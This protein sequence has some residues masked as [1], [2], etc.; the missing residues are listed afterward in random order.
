MEATTTGLYAHLKE[1]GLQGRVVPIQHL[2]DLQNQ[3]QGR[4]E[5]GEFE[6]EFY[7]ERLA[8]FSFE[9]PPKMPAPAA[10]IV[11][12]VP[13]PQ[14]RVSFT[15]QG[16]SLALVLPPTYLRYREVARETKAWVADW[17]APLGYH[18]VTA[19]LPQKLL[20]VC[21]GLAEYGR[22]NITYVPG[23]GSFQQPMA[24][25]SDL[26]PPEPDTWRAPQMMARCDKC[27][28]C[29][30]KCPTGA[31][32][33]DR[34]LLHAER[35][36]VYHNERSGEHPFPPWI[37]PAAHNSVMG[38]MTCQQY[39]PEDK[40]FLGWFEGDAEFTEEETALLL[41]GAKPEQL[42]PETKAKL[43]RL[44]LFDSLDALP[45]NLGVLL[46]RPSQE[47]GPEPRSAPQ[48]G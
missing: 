7:R 31:I 12:A 29:Q 27:H 32:G 44:E 5:R 40:P 41:R 39:C 3:V 4:R 20:S 6:D 26:P 10:L 11:V 19:K 30:L 2:R 45:R 24:W 37:D 23:M 16:K 18:L 34:F 42:L 35:C 22:N 33:K 46:E 48:A 8:F 13:R 17:L 21:S 9:P 15:W 36:L 38:C 25:F 28:A 14:T 43:E 1:R 47:D